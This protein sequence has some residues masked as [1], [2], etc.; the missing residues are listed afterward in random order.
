MPRRIRSADLETRTARLKLPVRK[1]PFAV[2]VGAGVHL[3]YRRNAK[4]GSWSIKARDGKG[5][6]WSKGFAHADDIE[7]ANGGSILD[8]W[9]AIDRARVLARSNA[10]EGDKPITVA[11]ALDQYEADLRARNGDAGNA[12][13][14]RAHLPGTLTDKL[15]STLTARDLQRVRDAM[16]AKGS[17]RDTI[18]RTGS[19]LK[20]ALTLAAN[21]DERIGNRSAWR[22][23]LAR[24]PNA[25][26]PRNVILADDKVIELIGAAYV[27]D[28]ALGLMVKVA[29]V[30]GAR[31]G[32]LARLEVQDLQDDPPRLFMPASRKGRGRKVE[33]RPVPIPM[34]LA[35]KLKV[36]SSG[37]AAEAPLLLKQHGSRWRKGDHWRPF[38]QAAAAAGLDPAEITLYALRHSSIVRELL[39]GVPVRVTAAKHDTSVAMV[40]ATY[41]KYISDHADALS[42]RALLDPNAGQVS[43]VTA[44]RGRQ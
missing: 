38:Q 13:R 11:A 4:A 1:K 19:A 39:A 33:R 3:L 24:L 7:A 5:G 17:T 23:G 9:Q 16:L 34:S 6:Y 30:T 27:I 37:R 42:R 31:A 2:Q 29:A 18:N 8:Y 36:A 26:R 14:V 25:G 41:S 10:G 43:N 40:E 28:R 32:Q 12:A 44:L 20:A 21:R 22:I 15:V 35:A